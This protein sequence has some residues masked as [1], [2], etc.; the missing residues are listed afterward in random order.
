MDRIRLLHFADLHIGVET[1]GAL[2]PA[3]GIH[4]R[5]LDFLKRFDELIDYGL[6]HDVGVVVFAGDAYRGHRPSPTYQ[7][8]FAERVKRLSDAGVPVVLLS[9][10]HDLPTRTQRASALDIFST[11]D[12]P[13][14][15]VADV[16]GV[17]IIETRQGPIQVAAIPYPLQQRLLTRDERR[18]L[19]AEELERALQ[20]AVSEKLEALKRQLDPSVPAVLAAHLSVSGASPSSERGMRVG[21]GA[22]LPPSA[23]N[24]PAWDYVALGHIH[25]H[26]SMNEDNHPPIVYA[27]S[28]ERMDFD[29]A[30]EP[31]GFCWVELARGDTAWQFVELDA[32]PFVTIRA[33]LRD[34][35]QP[36]EALARKI[37]SHDLREAVVRLV[38]HLRADQEVEV[39]E[40]RLRELLSDA[41]VIGAINRQVEREAR[42]RLGERAPEEMTDREL[43]AKYLEIKGTPPERIEALLARAERIF[44]E[45]TET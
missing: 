29:E 36:L 33:D 11:F 1:Y 13:N 39:P 31:K 23:L 17:H 15:T 19:S 22:A 18:G 34:T 38:V 12:V 41:Y 2:D 4:S 37:D 6:T 28:V 27:G 5:V 42:V 43:L 7:R 3:R 25:R 26:Q 45:E 16:E 14:V 9:G 40:Y 30:D 8:A 24:D 44:E 20:G 10:N 32:R 21:R 35:E